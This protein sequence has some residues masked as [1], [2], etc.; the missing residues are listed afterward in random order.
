MY[1]HPSLVDTLIITGYMK[2]KM[3]KYEDTNSSLAFMFYGSRKAKSIQEIPSYPTIIWL[4]GGPGKS[5]VVGNYMEIG[6]VLFKEG[7]DLDENKYTWIN[8]Y[9]VLFVG[10]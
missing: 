8:D 10:I 2:V 5:S 4:S 1:L 9:N 3:A 6:P 7:G